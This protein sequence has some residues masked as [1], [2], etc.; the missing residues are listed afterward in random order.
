[1]AVTGATPRKQGRPKDVVGDRLRLGDTATLA[2]TVLRLWTDA[3]AARKA[4]DDGRRCDLLTPSGQLLSNVP[5][6]EL[7]P[8]EEAP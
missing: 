1:M 6:S 5:V 3:D 2:V 4:G 7:V 8:A